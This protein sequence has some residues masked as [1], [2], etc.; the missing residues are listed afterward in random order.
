MNEFVIFCCFSL[1]LSKTPLYN[2]VCDA[3]LLSVFD[4]RCTA[5]HH[6]VILEPLL[7]DCAA[8]SVV[9]CEGLTNA[10]QRYFHF[11][12]SEEGAFLS[13]RHHQFHKVSSFIT[14]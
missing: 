12:V 3:L 4:C 8:V 6:H 7:L 13:V 14:R 11:I 2:S 5:H 1:Q 9:H 10:Q